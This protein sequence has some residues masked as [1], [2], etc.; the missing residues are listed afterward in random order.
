MNIK[1]RT[2]QEQTNDVFKCTECQ[3][4]FSEKW[5]LMNHKK[6]NHEV[7]EICEHF[8][9]DKCSFSAKT[10]WNLHQKPN[11]KH[12]STEKTSSSDIEVIKCYTCNEA[13]RTRNKMMKHRKKAHIELVKECRENVKNDC[14]F[15]TDTC[16]YKHSN[17][18][19]FQQDPDNM[20]PPAEK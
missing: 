12:S 4:Q 19:D 10:C 15:T 18:Q 9:K 13:F 1:H 7:T 2:T 8:L 3:L 6:N 17:P 16:W 14:D 11:S 20:A 5:N